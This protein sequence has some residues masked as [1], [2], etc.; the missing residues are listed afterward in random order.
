MKNKLSKRLSTN[1]KVILVALISTSFFASNATTHNINS[2]TNLSSFN[3][4]I[5]NG[6]TIMIASGITLTV[7]QDRVFTQTNLRIIADGGILAWSGN[8]EVTLT[9]TSKVYLW[10]GGTISTA[11]PCNAVKVLTIGASSATCNGGGGANY[12]FTDIN[13]AGGFAEFMI[14]PV[15]LLSFDAISTESSKNQ[16]VLTWSTAQEVN[17]SHFVVMKSNDGNTWE[18]IATVEGMGNTFENT[19]YTYTDNSPASVNYYKLIQV[20]FDGTETNLGI[21]FVLS[22]PTITKVEPVLFPNPVQNVLNVKI[23]NTGTSNASIEI[24]DLSGK[25]I[26]TQN[27]EINEIQTIQIS[28]EN[29]ATGIYTVRITLNNQTS[30]Q[31][32][33]KQ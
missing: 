19:T 20:D 16:V 1:I 3:P 7:D 32:I 17:N 25:I 29:F 15:D 10:N 11:N 28:T 21:R 9:N 30:V 26:F 2:N 5:S 6:D 27:N 23:E 24:M 13:A 33:V 22:N 8:H 31:R 14:L 12:S 4:S 18:S